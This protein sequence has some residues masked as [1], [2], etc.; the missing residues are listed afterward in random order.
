M[1]ESIQNQPAN[2]PSPI[3]RG[4]SSAEL[5]RDEGTT[6]GC[7]LRRDSSGLITISA[8]VYHPN[9][10]RCEVREFRNTPAEA[11]RLAQ[12]L[13]ANRARQ[14]LIDST[15][16]EHKLLLEKLTGLG[17]R[18]AVVNRLVV[19]SQVS[20][21][22]SPQ[23]RFPRSDAVALARLA[24]R[25]QPTFIDINQA[26]QEE[27][28]LFFKHLDSLHAQCRQALNRIDNILE[29]P[30]A[31]G[32]YLSAVSEPDDNPVVEPEPPVDAPLSQLLAL[33]P[34]SP[35]S[36][37]Q[38]LPEP[39]QQYLKEAQAELAQ[40]RES[41]EA[42]EAALLEHA[43]ALGLED[44]I[45][46]M[47]TVPGVTALLA[48]R[49]IAEAGPDIHQRFSSA[50]AFAQAVGLVLRNGADNGGG[51]A[52]ARCSPRYRQL[53]RAFIEAA[54]QFAEHGDGPLRRW[55]DMYRRGSSPQRSIFALARRLAEST[56]W[57][58]I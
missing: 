9:T 48:L 46:R 20:L 43:G 35:S 12:W 30:A 23:S 14:V 7:R 53:K 11:L 32:Y 40:S 24:A 56:W 36:V 26:Q 13:R 25:Y 54:R 16:G 47:C 52:P 21:E 57:A 2:L 41:I 1:E 44:V 10:G 33:D 45:N 37:A 27:L 18:A 17:L 38:A 4:V 51:P 50:P 15:T 28:R 19:L 58:T 31:N 39:V 42:V 6:A 8:A 22:A 55:Y 49:V 3:E 34:D 5:R 29:G